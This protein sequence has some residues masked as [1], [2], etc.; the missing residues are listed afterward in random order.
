MQSWQPLRV[1]SGRVR[2]RCPVQGVVTVVREQDVRALFDARERHATEQVEVGVDEQ[3]LEERELAAQRDERGL[4]ARQVVDAADL[5][6]EAV[7]ARQAQAV[8]VG[9][10]AVRL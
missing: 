1:S 4:D 9:G 10:L 3:R 8:A 7:G 2:T 5:V 6:R